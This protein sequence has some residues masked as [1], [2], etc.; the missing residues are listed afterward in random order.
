MLTRCS[1]DTY[2]GDMTYPYEV[3]SLTFGPRMGRL[4][5]PHA[6]EVASVPTGRQVSIDH[7][8]YADGSMIVH[9]RYPDLFAFQGNP[10]VINAM[11]SLKDRRG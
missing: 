9:L 1:A 4:R 10:H 3:T 6:D 7:R 2:C 5:F 8:S 11:V